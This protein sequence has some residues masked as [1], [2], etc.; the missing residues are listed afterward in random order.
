LWRSYYDT[1]AI[2]E[3]LNPKKQRQDM[4]V[5]YWKYLTEMQ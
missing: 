5:K 3:R 4:P 1:I 2:R